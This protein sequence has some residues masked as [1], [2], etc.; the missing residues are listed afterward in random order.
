MFVPKA[1]ANFK[2]TDDKFYDAF[3]SAVAA[4]AALYLHVRVYLHRFTWANKFS[5]FNSVFF[6]GL[7][8]HATALCA[9]SLMRLSVCCN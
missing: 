8:T 1:N 5:S 2:A 6:C 3:N 7:C 9:T 4:A